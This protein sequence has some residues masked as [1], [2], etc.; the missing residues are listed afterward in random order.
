MASNEVKEQAQKI[1]ECCAK[2]AT[3]TGPADI[4]NEVEKIKQICSAIE[5][6]I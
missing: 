6:Q 2:L 3:M 5:N 1:A 4:R